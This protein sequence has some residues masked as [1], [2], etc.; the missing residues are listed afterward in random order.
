MMHAIFFG[1]ECQQTIFFL[2][3]FWKESMAYLVVKDKMGG[4]AEAFANS[5]K[6]LFI[7]V[8]KTTVSIYKSSPSTVTCQ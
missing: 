4:L 5:G 6:L 1:R 3:I 7:L 8:F 2:E